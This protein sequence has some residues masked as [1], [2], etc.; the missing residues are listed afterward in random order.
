MRRLLHGLFLKDWGGGAITTLHPVGTIQSLELLSG[1][2]AI[3]STGQFTSE[4]LEIEDLLA[5]TQ[6]RM[7]L[8]LP[9]ILGANVAAPSLEI[10]SE[11]IFAAGSFLRLPFG[12]LIDISAAATL[13]LS[14]IPDWAPGSDL[15]FIIIED[16]AQFSGLVA[17]PRLKLAARLG[18]SISDDVFLTSD[19]TI[20]D[21]LVIE[22]GDLNIGTNELTMM[23]GHLV[24]DSDGV[25]FDGASDGISG[26][27]SDLGAKLIF[28]GPTEITLGGILELQSVGLQIASN[29]GDVINVV[30]PPGEHQSINVIGRSVELDSG[31]LDLGIADLVINSANSE[32]FIARGG[33]LEASRLSALDQLSGLELPAEEVFPFFD[34]AYGEVVMIGSGTASF[35]LDTGLSIPHLRLN[36]S[37]SFETESAPLTVTNR[38][39]FGENGASF[40][41]NQSGDLQLASGTRI[42]RRGSGSLSHHPSFGEEVE[43]YYDLDDGSVTSRNVGYSLESLRT[44]LEIPI[45]KR[46]AVLGVLAGNDASMI[47]QIELASDLVVSDALLIYSG[48]LDVNGNQLTL[49]AQSIIVID[50]LD[51]NAPPQTSF[52]GTTDPQYNSLGAYDLSLIQRY[53]RLDLTEELISA[54]E[55]PRELRIEVRSRTGGGR[56]GR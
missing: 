47:H 30:T 3:Q 31:I 6:G 9:V 33:S 20:T 40:L 56:R 7:E 41:T 45:S 4:S 21:A 2:V 19:I 18:S 11:L 48:A 23:G 46:V 14:Q 26:N 54:F 36:G 53:S 12:G 39:V 16:E 34:D 24:V 5:I 17:I 52:G 32:A 22:N 25:P 43:V 49:D 42:V 1:T 44:G 38:F 27:V 28:R 10:D 35:R 37:V 15:G 29:P 8:H 50:N 51:A 55:N 13:S